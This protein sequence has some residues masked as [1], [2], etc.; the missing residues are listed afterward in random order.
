[1]RLLVAALCLVAIACSKPAHYYVRDLPAGMVELHEPIFVTGATELRGAR[2]GTALHM[3]PDFRGAAAVVI[4]GSNVWLHDFSIDG[5]RA[6]LEIRQG[7]PPYDRTFAAFTANNG[8]AATSVDTLDVDNVRFRN[9][10]GFAILASRI[11]RMNVSRVSVEDSGSRNAAGRNNTT[12]GILIEEGSADFSVANCTFRNILGSALWTHSLYTSPRNERGVFARNRIDAVGRDAIQV[13]HAKDMTVADN[14]ASH[15]GFPLDASD[16]EARAIPVGIDTA[17]NAEDAHYLDNRIAEINGKCMDLDGLHDSE[18]RGNVCV[19]RNPP[20]A[21][22]L[23]N[24]A[25]VMNDTN[26]DMRTRNIRIVENRIERPVFGA[27]FVIGES[28]I[29]ARNILLDLNTAHCNQNVAH[30]QC[31]YAAADPRILEAGVYLGR[32][33]ERPAPARGNVVENNLITGW[34]MKTG[35]VVAAPDI[36][37][38]W[39][40]VRGNDCR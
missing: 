6:A 20:A 28:N 15:I 24:Y 1:M 17:G 8:I 32:G 5:N 34:G 12:G 31:N 39:N 26:P 3:A 10:A 40:I 7:L 4:R 25:I 29:I 27:V 16:L 30:Y 36:P 38:N 37:T 22:P 13:G 19:N 21:Y 23:G 33:A 2:Q 18:I 14:L 35:C 9:I 11:A